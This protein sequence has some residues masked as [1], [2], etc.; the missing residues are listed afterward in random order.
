MKKKIILGKK[1]NF[2]IPI[3]HPNLS[4]LGN[5]E[6]GGYILDLNV[7]KKVKH[8]LSFGVGD[9]W[10]FEEACLKK[11]PQIIIK[12]F[13][14]SI[15]IKEFYKSFFK[16][17]RRFLT[18]RSNFKSIKNTFKILKNYNNFKKFFKKKNIFYYP[19]KIT[20]SSNSKLDKSLIDILN[21]INGKVIIKCDIEGDEYDL[22]YN[23]NSHLKNVEIILVEFHWVEKN[24]NS[25]K[26]I[27]LQL[28]KNYN[29]VHFHVNNNSIFKKSNKM[30]D[31]IE[32]TFLRKKKNLDSKKRYYFPIRNLD[33]PNNPNISD[34]SVHFSQT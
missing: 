15:D 22:L 8:L 30:P 5:N 2:L 25:F 31:Y 27:I 4:R 1:Y 9:N 11:N 10:T 29:I 23:L 16:Y 21:S 14:Y 6:D 7:L 20:Q 12:I 17:I 3:L 26:K 28:K 19:N 18:F 34:Y 32:L 13:D 24:F 33:F